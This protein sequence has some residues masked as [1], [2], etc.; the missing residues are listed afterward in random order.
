MI[1]SVIY[2]AAAK[3]VT[4]FVKNEALT[5]PGAYTLS[6]AQGLLKADGS[7]AAVSGT[8]YPGFSCFAEAGK[9]SVISLQYKKGGRVLN[10]ALGQSNF[11]IEAVAA[12]MSGTDY[13]SLPYTVYADSKK[14]KPLA[15]G[16][17]VFNA[18]GFATF[19]AEITGRTIAKGDSI[20]IDFTV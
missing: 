7:A 20:T 19:S 13:R 14:T 6:A 3:K 17:A 12:N 1:E 4:L 9:V 8:V 16:T 15:S 5:A 18:E 2:E 11:T 10:G